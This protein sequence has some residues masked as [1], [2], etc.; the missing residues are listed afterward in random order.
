MGRW[1][2]SRL[3]RFAVIRVMAGLLLATELIVR[4]IGLGETD[5][6]MRSRPIH[7]DGSRVSQEKCGVCLAIH[8]LKAIVGTRAVS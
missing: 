5:R 2:D 3:G 7:K 4:C 8:R 6:W 1:T